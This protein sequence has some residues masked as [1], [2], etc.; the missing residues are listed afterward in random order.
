MKSCCSSEDH[1]C[2]GACGSMGAS[3][4]SNSG[5]IMNILPDVE[6]IFPPHPLDLNQL[7]EWKINLSLISGLKLGTGNSIE[8]ETL[9]Q[10][11]KLTID[12]TFARKRLDF[13]L[14]IERPKCQWKDTC[15]LVM[16][17]AVKS[18]PERDIEPLRESGDW[19][20]LLQ[21]LGQMD[22][23]L[24]FVN[25][26]RQGKFDISPH[27]SKISI[28]INAML[29]NSEILEFIRGESLET[30]LDHVPRLYL[31]ELKQ[32]SQQDF[33]ISN[34]SLK[35]PHF[36]GR[37]LPAQIE[38]RKPRVVLA[39]MG[40]VFK[41]IRGYIKEKFTNYSIFNILTE[42]EDYLHLK[43]NGETGSFTFYL[44]SPKFVIDPLRLKILREKKGN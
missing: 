24:S 36:L 9:E 8:S 35:L 23:S 33:K 11:R 44:L 28:F 41:T 25:E 1:S 29:E 10:L 21:D 34:W 26:N 37:Y 38:K 7:K 27:V 4:S 3:D 12:L 19:Q 42:E 2:C 22:M 16:P 6:W 39:I 40:N 5:G 14:V 20:E 31:T 17:A 15:G 18:E 43:C 32:A 30:P 13:M